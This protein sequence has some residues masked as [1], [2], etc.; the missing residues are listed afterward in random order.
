M[1]AP[2]AGVGP[3]PAASAAT[4]G[5]AAAH[6]AVRWSRQCGWAGTGAGGCPLGRRR[7]GGRPRSVWGGESVK[8]GGGGG[9]EREREGATVRGNAAPGGGRVRKEGGRPR[10]EGCEGLWGFVVFLD[11]VLGFFL[12]RAN[13]C[14]ERHSIELPAGGRWGGPGPLGGVWV[15]QWRGWRFASPPPRGSFPRVL[16]PGRVRPGREVRRDVP[17][18]RGEGGRSVSRR[19]RSCP[20]YPGPRHPSTR[21]ELTPQLTFLGAF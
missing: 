18:A 9:T 12:S 17:A 16:C 14:V 10:G 11:R 2:C 6:P 15:S 19:R 21:S 1:L 8:A 4:G 3:G 20:S 7:W 5:P 13:T